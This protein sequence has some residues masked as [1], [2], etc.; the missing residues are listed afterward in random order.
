MPNSSSEVRTLGS[1][2]RQAAA[3]AQQAPAAQRAEVQE[4]QEKKRVAA[5]PRR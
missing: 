4:F 3:A 5:V 2:R 1:E